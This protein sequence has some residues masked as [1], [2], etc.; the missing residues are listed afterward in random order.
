MRGSR[1]Q[2]Q[3]FI[4]ALLPLLFGA[5]TVVAQDERAIPSLRETERPSTNIGLAVG[6]H[7]PEFH[8]LDQDSKLQT[9]DSIRGPKGA[10]LYFY[11]SADWCIYCRSQLVETEIS[12]EVLTKNG[13]GVI[14][15]SYDSPAILKEFATAQKIQYPLLSDPE[16]KMIRDF[17]VLDATLLPTDPG[18]GVPYH[19]SY[20]VDENGL[21]VAKLFD[22]EATPAHSTGIV[23]SRLFGSP[24]NTHEKIVTHNRLTMKYYASMNF[25]SPG[26]EVELIMD[27]TVND[28]VHVYAPAEKH[29]K[30]IDWQI[31]EQPNLVVGAMVSPPAQEFRYKDETAAAYAGSFRL[32]RRVTVGKDQLTALDS[33]GNVALKGSFTFQACD[34]QNCYTPT[35][36][37][38]EWKLA[39]TPPA[40]HRSALSAR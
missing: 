25:V 23:V 10:V 39:P 9:F 6:E 31:A 26:D 27:V 18:Y 12:R 15:V 32:S 24:L 16:S 4:W 38:L 14:G 13:F 34:D 19:G 20:I 28:G 8:A 33:Q 40:E 3:R 35:T 21:V 30:P 7:I 29:Y 37:P 22:P 1:L 36:I 5:G 11:R 2:S 17:K